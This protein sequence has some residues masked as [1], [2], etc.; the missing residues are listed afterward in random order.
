MLPVPP[1]K[2]SVTKQKNYNRHRMRSISSTA[3]VVNWFLI[4]LSCSFVTLLQLKNTFQNSIFTDSISSVL[5][6]SDV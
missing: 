3:I 1:L 4:I 6:K 2:F 5:S